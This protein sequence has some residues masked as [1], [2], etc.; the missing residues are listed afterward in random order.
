MATRPRSLGDS[1]TDIHLSK[2][3]EGVALGEHGYGNSGGVDAATVLFGR[4]HSLV[5]MTASFLFEGEDYCLRA[6]EV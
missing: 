6:F 5:A 2:R 3:E 4:G 1:L